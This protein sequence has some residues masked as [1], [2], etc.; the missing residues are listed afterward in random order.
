MASGSRTVVYAALGGNG[1]IA[2]TKLAA[3]ALTGSAAMLSEGV[4]SVADTG[5]QALLL[6]GLRQADRPP[7][8]RFPFGRGKE[9]YFWSF[10]V[11]ILLFALGAGV[12]L[13]EG[14]TH[15][16]HPEPVERVGLS[17]AVLGIAFVFEAFAWLFAYREFQ[18][19][20]G[21][22]SMLAAVR[23]S[24]DPS[25]FVVLFEDTAAMLGI[26]VAFAGIS[27]G[28]ALHEP[29]L[30]GA[31]SILIGL[32][33]AGTAAWLAYETKG[34]LVGESAKPETVAKIR[35]LAAAHPSVRRVNEVLT[36]HMGPE[37]ILLNLSLD[38]APGLPSEELTRVIAGLDA[39]IKAALP[40]VKRVFIEAEARQASQEVP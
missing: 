20:R 25:V 27:L 2:A 16:R 12:S 26:V 31:A 28:H 29:R 37:F 11:A 19:R 17:Y 35:D 4:H 40:R 39:E 21:R 23:D 38:F 9:V 1:L 5:N 22:R 6:L 10:V 7:D 24:K 30:D 18:R 14:V 15:V 34:L 36:L 3:A 33:L 32:I 8:A 13:Y